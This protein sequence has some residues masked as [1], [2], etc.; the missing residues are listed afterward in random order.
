MT[1]L[2]GKDVSDSAEVVCLDV[3]VGSNLSIVYEAPGMNDTHQQVK[4]ASMSCG[5]K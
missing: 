3:T 1:R 5:A 4:L 2:L